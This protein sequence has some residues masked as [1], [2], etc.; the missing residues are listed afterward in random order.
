MC[1]GSGGR[2]ERRAEDAGAESHLHAAVA[3]MGRLPGVRTIE[4]EHRLDQH[5]TVRASAHLEAW[6]VIHAMHS[7]EVIGVKYVLDD[8]LRRNTR[9]Q[10]KAGD[11][12]VAVGEAAKICYEPVLILSR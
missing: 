9:R 1:S 4:I 3:I 7:L 5:L 2:D 11:K 10:H 12:A 8:I 6:S